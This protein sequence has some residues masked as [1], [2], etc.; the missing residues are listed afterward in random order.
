M[1][2]PAVSSLSRRA[3]PLGLEIRPLRSAEEFRAGVALQR[4]TWGEQ[5]SECVP[6]AILKVAQRIGGVTAGA[7]D[8]GGRLLGFVFGMAGV[9]HGRPI[10]WSHML[11]VLPEARDLG[12]GRRL[13]EYQRDRVRE[14]GVE[15]IYWTYDPLVARNA[16]LNLNRLGAEV[17]E[18]VENMYGES[19]SPLHQSGTDRFIVTW[20]IDGGRSRNGP[21]M[22]LPPGAEDAPVLNAAASDGGVSDLNAPM[23]RVE[24]PADLD[25][26][27]DAAAARW[28]ATTREAFVPAL[29]QGYRIAGFYR[30]AEQG[31][32]YYVLARPGDTLEEDE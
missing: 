11:A 31:P 15:R 17:E 22:D 29:E 13:K 12:L 26:L 30:K 21:R 9:R 18:Y 4:A 6:P 23:V 1:R 24:V 10:H 16:H 7:F 27:P 3:L 2:R 8:A 19:T 14:L 32:C 5:F 20:R 28:R 25:A